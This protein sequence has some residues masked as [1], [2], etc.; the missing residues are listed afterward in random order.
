MPALSWPDPLPASGSVRLRPFRESDLPLVAELA[1]DPYLPSIGTVPA[2]YSAAAGLAYLDRQ[3]QRLREGAGYSFAIADR[4]DRAR[5]GAS[6]WPH[7]GGL[8]SGG[9]MLAP[10]VRRQGLG[11]DALLALTAFAWTLAD[12]QRVEL[13][14]EPWN[15]ASIRVAGRCGYVR[16]ALLPQHHTVGGRG[17]DMLRFAA[18]RP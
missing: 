4:D 6:L 9:Y 3:H 7:P 11:T 1:G 2:V 17:R 13:F 15:Q 10:A 14:I 5:G 8:A 12:L 16:E 18:E